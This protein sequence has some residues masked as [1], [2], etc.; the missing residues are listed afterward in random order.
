MSEPTMDELKRELAEARADLTTRRSACDEESERADRAERELAE[1][2]AERDRLINAVQATPHTAY[3]EAVQR[4]CDE[5][6]SQQK[7]QIRKL[8]HQL[9]V[10]QAALSRIEHSA[11]LQAHLL[12]ESLR[13]GGWVGA[14][15]IADV[16]A[17]IAE[18]A[19]S[20]TGMPWTATK[21]AS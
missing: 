8:E 18:R 16:L 12:R 10:M 6:M 20:A 3:L 14:E 19:R 7:H 9:A 5:R 17:Q 4:A 13:T 11:N 1:G 2:L 15:A 21:N